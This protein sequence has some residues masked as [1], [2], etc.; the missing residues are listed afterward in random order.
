M[1]ESQ[2]TE[3]RSWGATLD[4]SCLLSKRSVFATILSS[5]VTP[6]ASPIITHHNQKGYR[7]S[8]NT[9]AKKAFGTHELLIQ[10]KSGLNHL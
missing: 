7:E 4:Q 3:P 2:D 10:V 9:L 6:P 8:S 1:D 5:P